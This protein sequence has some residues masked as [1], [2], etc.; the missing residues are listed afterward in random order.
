VEKIDR[1]MV[2]SKKNC[3]PEGEMADKWV[4]KK[5]RGEIKVDKGR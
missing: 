1:K 4:Q 5:T 2:L 3:T